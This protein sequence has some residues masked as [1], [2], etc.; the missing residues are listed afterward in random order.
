MRVAVLSLTRDRLDYTRHCFATL[1]QHAGCD[2]DHYVLDQGS[3]DGTKEWLRGYKPTMLVAIGDNIGISRG[4]NLLLN[5]CAPKQ[6]EVIVKFDNDCEL[7]QPDT[8]STVAALAL[9]GHALLSPRINGLRNTPQPNGT[10]P[11]S[12]ETILSLPMIGGIFLASPASAFDEFR[13]DES[14]PVWGTDDDTFCGWW[15]ARGGRIGYV[16]RFVANHY[17]TTDGQW[18]RFP[19]YFSRKIA[20]GLPA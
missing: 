9:E 7:T 18:S 13:Y 2:F 4:M 20:E 1:N 12:G 17:E 19:E 5:A 11:I 3:T 16:E 10:F 8:L 14:A 15:R 6:Y